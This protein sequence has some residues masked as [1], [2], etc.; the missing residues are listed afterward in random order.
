[1]IYALAGK[2]IKPE[3]AEILA[4]GEKAVYKTLHYRHYMIRRIW[5]NPLVKIN[6]SVK[7]KLIERDEAG[8]PSRYGKP[9][10]GMHLDPWLIDAMRHLVEKKR[11]VRQRRKWPMLAW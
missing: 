2:A 9:L 7:Y 1:M 6:R 11:W 3:Q 5:N 4:Q 10:A 8:D